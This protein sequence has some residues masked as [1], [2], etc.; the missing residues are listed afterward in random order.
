MA[1]ITALI[2]SSATETVHKF[3]NTDWLLTLLKI[4]MGL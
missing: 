3:F 2:S 4:V 1:F